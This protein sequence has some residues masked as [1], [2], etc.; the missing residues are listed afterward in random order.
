MTKAIDRSAHYY[1]WD[2][3]RSPYNQVQKAVWANKDWDEED[4]AAYGIDFLSNGFK[5]REENDDINAD[6]GAYVYFAFA[7]HPFVSSKGIPVH[8]R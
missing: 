7:E 8:A 2:N 1:M 3:K 5:L 4:H 6:G